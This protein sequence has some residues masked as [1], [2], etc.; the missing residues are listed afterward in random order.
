MSFGLSMFRDMF[1]A[2]SLKG[3]TLALVDT[4][5]EAL[6]R[7]TEL[8]RLLNNAAAEDTG[9]ARNLGPPEKVQ[10]LRPRRSGL[11]GAH[12]V[13]GAPAGRIW[14][15]A[16]HSFGARPAERVQR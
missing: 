13:G 7:M 12:D 3:S 15:G 8:A 14:A 4:N 16:D 1:F 9:R 5:P 11:V 6:A 2:E 10:A